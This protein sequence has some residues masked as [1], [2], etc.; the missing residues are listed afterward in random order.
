MHVPAMPAN[1]RGQS[2]QWNLIELELELELEFELELDP[3]IVSH[4]L[5]S[6]VV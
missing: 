4:Y 1:Q 3:I 6:S 5:A 2:Y